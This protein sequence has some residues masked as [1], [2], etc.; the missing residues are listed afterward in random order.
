MNNKTL[1]EQTADSIM[2]YIISNNMQPGDKIPNE[3]ELAELLSV[4]R[5]T[6]R[7]GVRIL[8]SRNVLVIKRGAGTYI[9][10]NT[11]VPEDPLGLSFSR[12][13]YALA[14]DLI[15][16]RLI[17]EPEIASLAALKA[18]DKDIAA[19]MHKCD[20]VE[21]LYYSG[22]DHMPEDIAFHTAIARASGNQVIEKIVPIINTSVALFCN[23]TARTLK[24][25]TITT[26]RNVAKAIAEHDSVSAKYAMMMHLIYNRNKIEELIREHNNNGDL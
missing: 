15:E 17:L 1:P 5:S 24:E 9:A 25:E 8:V 19:I 18:T 2:E 10:D 4:G 16:L 13:K 26:H 6:V 11:G 14:A 21:E 7:E 12:D 23:L 22:A 20:R 3:F